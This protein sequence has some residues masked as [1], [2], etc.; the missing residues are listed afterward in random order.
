MNRYGFALTFGL[1]CAF[2]HAAPAAE[3]DLLPEQPIDRQVA[4]LRVPVS[5][6]AEAARL[7]DEVFNGPATDHKD[8]VVVFAI[9]MTKY[10]F[11]RAT[12]LDILTMRDLLTTCCEQP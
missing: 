5:S 8:R 3:K 2:I 7:M 10:L 4:L 12:K 11:V 6:P 9:P 1:L